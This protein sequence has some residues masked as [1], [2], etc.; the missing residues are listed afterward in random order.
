MNDKIIINAL[1]IETIIGLYPWEQKVRQTLLIDLAL[2]TDI[3]QAAAGDDLHHTINYEAVCEHVTALAKNN[4]Y[5]LI[6]TLAENI[7]S[8]ILADFTATAVS[9]TIKKCDNM[10]QVDHV[11]VSIERP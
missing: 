10:T 7:A 4:Q 3:R 1:R 5:N 2:S 11:G 9:V 6:E 8:M